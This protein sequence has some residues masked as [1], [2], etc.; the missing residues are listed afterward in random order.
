MQ[1]PLARLLASSRIGSNKMME[2]G[3]GGADRERG[4]WTAYS[5]TASRGGKRMWSQN[6]HVRPKGPN[7]KGF[8]LKK[9]KR[10]SLTFY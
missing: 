9:G 4:S 10:P 7:S 5:A 8:P 6:L 2:V 3:I 1:G